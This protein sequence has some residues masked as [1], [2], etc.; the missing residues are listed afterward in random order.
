MFT[1]YCILYINRICKQIFTMSDIN[2]FDLSNYSDLEPDEFSAL[3]EE[4]RGL[5]NA[6]GLFTEEAT[7]LPAGVSTFSRLICVEDVQGRNC[8]GP[9][10]VVW[11]ENPLRVYWKCLECEKDGVIEHFAGASD[12][13]SSTREQ[14]RNAHFLFPDSRRGSSPPPT[15]LRNY[16]P[17]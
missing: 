14:K 6:Y 3:P 11:S 13:S 17:S 8:Q 16:S 7:A 15:A 2:Y 1:W 4:E 10:T 12:L 9:I 5:V